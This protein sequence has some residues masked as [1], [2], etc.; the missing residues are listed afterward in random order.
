MLSGGLVIY[1][2][3]FHFNELFSHA[4]R[5]RC[6]QKPELT[7]SLVRNGKQDSYQP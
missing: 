7:G 1:L 2:F 3:I 5:V 4:V 6:F